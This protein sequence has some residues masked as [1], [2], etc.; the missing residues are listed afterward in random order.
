M[1]QRMHRGLCTSGVYGS[2]LSNACLTPPRSVGW[3]R[4]VQDEDTDADVSSSQFLDIA[5]DILTGTQ[6]PH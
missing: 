4:T 2:F 1:A 6:I 5:V 3:Q